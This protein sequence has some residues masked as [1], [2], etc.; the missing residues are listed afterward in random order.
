MAIYT[1]FGSEVEL[2]TACLVP[3]WIEEL[4]GEI[5]WHYSEKKPT[6]RT[7][8]ITAMP[9]WHVTGKDVESGELICDGGTF[10]AN[11]LRADNG[12]NEIYEAMWKLNPKHKDGFQDWCAGKV[13]I[14]HFEIIDEKMVA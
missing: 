7:K 3:I 6:K 11:E 1:R 9:C 14:T 5:K 13:P 4:P 8:K 12:T 2:L 10:S